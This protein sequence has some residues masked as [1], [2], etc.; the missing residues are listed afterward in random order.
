MS[1]QF[2]HTNIG[3]TITG[4]SFVPPPNV[5]AKIVKFVARDKPLEPTLYFSFS[6]TFLFFFFF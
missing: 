1:Q 2:F 4:K 5:S 3:F 6:F